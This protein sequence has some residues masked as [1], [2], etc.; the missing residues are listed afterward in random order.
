ME[1][2]F[3]IKRE[4]DFRWTKSAD[5]ALNTLKKRLKTAPIIG[6]ADFDEPFLLA[7]DASDVAAGGCLMQKQ[8]DRY[9][10]IGHCSKLFDKTQRGWSTIE[11]ELFAIKFSIETFEYFLSSRPFCIQSDHKPLTFIDKT[12]FKGSHKLRRWQMDLQNYDFVIQYIK[13]TDN[14]LADWLSRPGTKFTEGDPGDPKPAGK[15]CQLENSK[16]LV[17]IPSWCCPTDTKGKK[18]ENLQIGADH[19]K[20]QAY[21]STEGGLV[22]SGISTFLC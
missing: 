5:R 17:Y 22:N 4:K 10:I 11:K 9:V 15:F 18:L 8:G 6:Y 20:L 12:N 3:A 19:D 1:P 14:R 13:G 7:T 21:F 16:L 2:I